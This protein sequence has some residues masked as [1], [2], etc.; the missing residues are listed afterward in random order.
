MIDAKLVW[1]QAEDPYEDISIALITWGSIIYLRTL[2]GHSGSNLIDPTLQGQRADWTWNIPLH[3]PC[4]KQFQ[5]SFHYQQWTDTW[6]SKFEKKTN[7]VLLACWSKK[8]RS[9]R[10]RI[11]W[12]LC[13]TSCTIHAQS[14]EETMKMRYHGSMLILESKK[15]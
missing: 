14:M 7:G 13:T 10:P 5:S 8:W 6:R 3:L 11:Y 15:D 1:L 12:L 9:Q 4:G 2:H